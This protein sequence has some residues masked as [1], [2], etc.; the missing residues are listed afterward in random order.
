MHRRRIDTFV[1]ISVCILFDFLTDH[2][3]PSE[4]ERPGTR[5]RAFAHQAGLLQLLEDDSER[6]AYL[7]RICW[8]WR[9]DSD[10]KDR[11]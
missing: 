2:L 11:D 5:L 1:V 10:S 7:G 4:Q 3:A 9:Q 6:Y 8:L